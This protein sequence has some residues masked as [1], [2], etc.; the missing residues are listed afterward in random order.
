VAPVVAVVDVDAD[1]MRQVLDNLIDNAIRHSAA[2]EA[3]DVTV[4]VEALLARIEVADAGPGIPADELDRIFER[5][6]RLDPARSRT[7][8]GA[9]LGLSIA[10]SIVE[11]HGGRVTAANRSPTGAVL[12]IELSV[13]GPAPTALGT[14]DATVARA[15][16]SIG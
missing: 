10:R 12:S 4:T 3:V 1:R 13:V 9:G 15:G 11:L 8:A 5:L 16:P 2:G 6:H 7:D 14:G